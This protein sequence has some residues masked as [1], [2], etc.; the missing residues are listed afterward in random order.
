[1]TS[2]QMLRFSVLKNCFSGQDSAVFRIETPD[3]EKTTLDY[4]ATRAELKVE[5]EERVFG[6]LLPA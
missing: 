5:T 4:Y 2:N 1:M 3:Q 6:A